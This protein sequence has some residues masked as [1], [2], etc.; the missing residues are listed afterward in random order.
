ME[1]ISKDDP[2]CADFKKEIEDRIRDTRKMLV[3]YVR[4]QMRKRNE[5]IQ[6]AKAQRKAEH[7]ET[8]RTLRGFVAS[9]LESLKTQ[10]ECE[11]YDYKE[12]FASYHAIVQKTMD[13]EFVR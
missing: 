10:L 13:G 6:E 7:D 2:Q 1:Y 11:A 12:T 9:V 3:E 8:I 4:D 5:L